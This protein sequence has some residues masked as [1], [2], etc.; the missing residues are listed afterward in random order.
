MLER[1]Y[2][3]ML[4]N[5]AIPLNIQTSQVTTDECNSIEIITSPPRAVPLHVLVVPLTCILH[6]YFSVY[7]HNVYWFVSIWNGC[8]KF[9]DVK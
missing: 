9:V 5:A 7:T 1:I 8:L 2:Y 4:T 3:T 6:V